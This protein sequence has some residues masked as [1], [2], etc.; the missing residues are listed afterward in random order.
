[1]D[2]RGRCIIKL[3]EV[4]PGARSPNDWTS[5]LTSDWASVLKT[6]SPATSQTNE[7]DFLT[8]P[9][10]GRPVFKVASDVTSSHL[11]W[12]DSGFTLPKAPQEDTYCEHPTGG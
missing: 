9:A 10:L 6:K 3:F 12:E 11:L 5:V 1:M 2:H 7:G 4:K 8:W